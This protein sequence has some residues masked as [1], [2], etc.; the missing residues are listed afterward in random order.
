MGIFDNRVVAE[1]CSIGDEKIDWLAFAIGH[2][3]TIQMPMQSRGGN[4]AIGL[5]VEINIGD[6]CLA[7]PHRSFLFAEWKQEVLVQAPVQEC[8]NA[9]IHGE[10]F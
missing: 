2:F 6:Y 10:D 7:W 8:T 3:L 9:R 1:W 4:D 5:L